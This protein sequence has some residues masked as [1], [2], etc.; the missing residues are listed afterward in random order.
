MYDAPAAP[1]AT[2]SYA[3]AVPTVH[4]C[5][6]RGTVWPFT[7]SDPDEMLSVPI[8]ASIAEEYGTLPSGPR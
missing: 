4:T 3:P 2:M 1:A 8:D 6:P 5:M 7:T